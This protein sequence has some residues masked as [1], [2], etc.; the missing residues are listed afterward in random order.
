MDTGIF[1]GGVIEEGI[2][3]FQCRVA[4]IIGD[5]YTIAEKSGTTVAFNR[6]GYNIAEI[7]GLHDHFHQMITIIA[8]SGNIQK[9]IEFCRSVNGNF[10]VLC[11]GNLNKFGFVFTAVVAFHSAVP[12]VNN[13]DYF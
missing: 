7:N 10:G 3:C 6:D 9:K 4:A 1:N 11:N 13:N 12:P 8:T 2:D 5:V